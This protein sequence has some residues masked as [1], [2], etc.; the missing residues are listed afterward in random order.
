MVDRE[1]RQLELMMDR[2]ARFRSGD[3]G[4]GS[5]INDL[6]ALSDELYL[7]DEAWH[8]RFIDAWSDLEIPYAVALD[9]LAPLPD[10]SDWTVRNGPR[11]LE[12]L[13][14]EGFDALRR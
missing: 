4:I 8:D 9:E 10:A 2:I 3:L 14:A 5:T 1:R 11:S 6:M 7:A 12:E 13:V